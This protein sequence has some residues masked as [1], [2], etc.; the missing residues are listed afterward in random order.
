MNYLALDLGGSSIKYGI[1]DEEGNILSKGKTG[2]DRDSMEGL[3]Q[4]LE[5]LRDS[6][7]SDYE[8]V[9]VSMPGRIDTAKGIAHTGGAYSFIEHT[10]MQSFYASVFHKP[11]VVANDG[12]CAAAAESWKGSLKDVCNGAV[13]VIGTGI[14]GGII[15]NHEV[16]MGSNGGAGEFSWLTADYQKVWQPM[17][18]GKSSF[19]S[20]WSGLCSSWALTLKYA[21]LTGRNDVD[22]IAFFK[23][24]NAGNETAQKVFDQFASDMAAGISALQSVLDLECYAIGGGISEEPVVREAVAEKV[25]ELWK[26][27]PMMPCGKPSIVTTKYHNDANLIGAVHLYLKKQNH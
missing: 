27:R 14:G 22:G 4:I 10:D 8:G 7:N 5:S 19:S 16:F 24:L 12:K 20:I 25:D 26:L 18:F 13:I 11:V 23:D 6:L 9:A 2:T 21:E 3:G 1:L 15:L 17:E